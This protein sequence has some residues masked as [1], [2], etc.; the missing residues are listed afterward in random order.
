LRS[1]H[2]SEIGVNLDICC[3]TCCLGFE[4]GDRYR[5]YP[6]EHVSHD[7]T[8]LTNPL[9][10]GTAALIRSSAVF[11]TKSRILFVKAPRYK[12]PT[13]SSPLAPPPPPLLAPQTPYPHHIPSSDNIGILT[14]SAASASSPNFG[15]EISPLRIETDGDLEVYNIYL[16]CAAMGR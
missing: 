10:S 4:F 7:Q 16:Y 6:S 15:Q 8:R 9:I 11:S 12:S 14:L 5:A 2:A 13:A 3:Q 1:I